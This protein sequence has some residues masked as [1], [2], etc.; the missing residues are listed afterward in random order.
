MSFRFVAVLFSFVF[1]C[2]VVFGYFVACFVLLL[3]ALLLALFSASVLLHTYFLGPFLISFTL[4]LACSFL[5]QFSSCPF[6]LF[7]SL[8]LATSLQVFSRPCSLLFSLFLLSKFPFNSSLRLR[9]CFL[10]FFAL[11]SI[12]VEFALTLVCRHSERLK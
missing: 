3:L 11:S 5:F 8:I 12:E 1:L 2:A 7:L 6:F 9:L 4:L 10:L